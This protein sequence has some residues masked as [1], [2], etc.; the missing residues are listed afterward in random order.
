MT[1]TPNCF[2]IRSDQLV[3]L[4]SP[5]FDTRIV[6]IGPQE[7]EIWLCLYFG[8]RPSWIFQYGHPWGCGKVLPS[9]SSIL[10]VYGTCVQTAKILSGSALLLGFREL[11]AP[12]TCPDLGKM[13]GTLLILQS[14]HC[15]M[16]FKAVSFAEKALW[17]SR[18]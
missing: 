4:K 1:L 15:T 9:I 6:I 10:K 7:A 11:R 2:I 8:W 16:H 13:V 12:T 5:Y 14:L 3:A 17:R 18:S